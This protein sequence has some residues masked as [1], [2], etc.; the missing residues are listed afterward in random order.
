[1]LYSRFTKLNDIEGDKV[2]NSLPFIIDTHVHIF[3]DRI[4]MAI[5]KWFEK[6]AWP[7]RYKLT[8][9]DLLNYLL[10]RGIAHII[11]LQYAH[12]PG[13]ARELNLYMAKICQQ[14]NNKVTGIATVFPG[15]E[16]T[17]DIL[18]EAFN[19]GLKG[20]KLHAHVQCFD[21]NKK[22]MDI[23][24][25]LCSSENKPIIMHVGREPKSNAYNCDPYL[26]CNVK[27][28]ERVIKNYPKLKICV[29]HLGM[30]EFQ[31]YK[32]LIEKYDNIWLDTAMALTDYL[33]IKNP[34]ILKN[35]RTDRIMYGSD[36][37]NIPY[38][39]DHELKLLEKSQFSETAKELVSGKNA[40]HFFNINQT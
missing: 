29:P 36:F 6:Y 15:E 31:Q 39:W 27:K 21:M 14:F 22:Y 24:Y 18:S 35:I 7:I 13:I 38:A 32:A 25:D 23:I 20:L 30:D 1:M 4:F 40:V 11:A 37:P 16:G 33:P 5:W 10:E 2:P 8:S 26:L 19:N 34:V 28:L 3:P 17:K 12:K 9:I